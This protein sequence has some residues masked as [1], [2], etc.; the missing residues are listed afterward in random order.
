[1]FK[2]KPKTSQK[3]KAKKTPTALMM[4]GAAFLSVAGMINV[5]KLRLQSHTTVIKM[6]APKKGIYHFI[7][8][9]GSRYL[10]D[11]LMWLAHI[12]PT[13][14]RL[15]WAIITLTILIRLITMAINVAA[16]KINNDSGLHYQ[17]IKPQ[18]HLV[19]DTLRLE[20]VSNEQAKALKSLRQECIKVNHAKTLI[21]PVIVNMI[22]SIVI[23]SALYQSIAYSIAS[24]NQVFLSINLAQRSFLMNSLSSIMYAINSLL[25]WR[26]LTPE[27]KAKTSIIQYIFSPVSTFL[28]GYFMPSII[29]LYWITSASCLILQNLTTHYIILPKI[30]QQV[31]DNFKPQTVITVEKINNILNPSLKGSDRNPQ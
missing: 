9:H 12:F 25:N 26:S 10:H 15:G 23:V 30:R 22:L 5:F 31:A 3:N 7:Y 18:I 2:R 29:T 17:Q 28:S 11:F 1:M 6:L 8:I 16:I 20:P 19:D 24:K 27:A 14:N 21:W 13:N 4:E